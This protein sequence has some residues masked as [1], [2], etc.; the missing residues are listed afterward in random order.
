MGNMNLCTTILPCLTFTTLY[1]A[2][3]LLQLSNTLAINSPSPYKPVDNIILN[4]GSSDNSTALDGRTWTRDV[5]SKFFPQELS[6]NQASL[7]TNSLKQSLSD[8]QV[9]YTTARLFVSP[10]TYIF[11]GMAIGRVWIGYT[12]TL[13]E[14]FAHEYPIINTHT[15]IYYPWISIPYPTRNP[16]NFVFNPKH[17][18]VKTNQS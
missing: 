6:Q 9:P 4:C 16:F 10:F 12:H 1:L 15:R 7:A 3:L 18:D 13:P 17:F 8:S 11:L 5:N 2:F 14:K